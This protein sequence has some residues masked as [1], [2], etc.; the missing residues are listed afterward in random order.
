L[1]PFIEH[2]YSRA[3]SLFVPLQLVLRN[4]L[5]GEKF[6]NRLVL[7]MDDARRC[8]NG[9]PWTDIMIEAILKNENY[10]GNLVYNRTSRRLGQKL[11]N[12]PHHLWVRSAAA[13]DPMVDQDLFARAQKIMA[14]RY[15]SIP[16]DEMLRRLRL[17][18]ARK[19]KLSDG[20]IRNTAGLPSTNVTSSILAR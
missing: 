18:L 15:I 12:N 2:G 8:Q 19:G 6:V 13:V 16:E 11:V 20:I 14:E 10:V 17:T 4:F 5:H 9:R 1:L 7:Q 3:Q